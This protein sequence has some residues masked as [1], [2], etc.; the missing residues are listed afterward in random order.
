M[1][2][3]YHLC[4]VALYRHFLLQIKGQCPRDSGF[5]CCLDTLV[6]CYKFY[7]IDLRSWDSDLKSDKREVNGRSF[8]YMFHQT[9]P[10]YSTAPHRIISF[11][12]CF[13]VR[14]CMCTRVFSLYSICRTDFNQNRGTDRDRDREGCT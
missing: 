11:L 4:L 3:G 1:Y 2:C 6:S 10:P 9:F 14:S 13:V 7:A 5:S 8:V 12:S